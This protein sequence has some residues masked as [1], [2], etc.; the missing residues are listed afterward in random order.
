[1][2]TRKPVSALGVVG[3]V[4]AGGRSRRFGVDKARVEVGG[5]PL[6]VRTANLL[7]AVL[8]EVVIVGDTTLLELW[9]ARTEEAVHR[10]IFMDDPREGP[11][12]AVVVVWRRLSRPLV[13]LACDLP[14]MDSETV[15]RL[16]RPGRSIE[17]LA[18]PML[19]PEVVLGDEGPRRQWLAAHYGAEALQLM[20]TAWDK[21]ERS[22]GRAAMAAAATLAPGLWNEAATEAGGATEADPW[23]ARAFADADTPESLDQILGR[24]QPVTRPA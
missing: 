3:V 20:A 21:G 11:L 15:A 24:A 2:D 12:G 14:L 17:E 16:A 6:V 9:Q 22:I 4:L 1:M 18:V 19:V 10:P 23:D 8:G 7:A 13:V 5:E